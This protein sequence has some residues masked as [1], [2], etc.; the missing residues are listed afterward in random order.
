[1]LRESNHL[2]RRAFVKLAGITAA[3]SSLPAIAG[4]G[5][6]PANVVSL[7]DGKTLDGWIQ[8]ENNATSLTPAQIT[9]TAAFI[10]KIAKSTDALSSFLHTQLDDSIKTI[11]PTFS[12]ANTDAKAVLSAL[13]KNLNSVIAGP[14][15]YDAT[16]F[17]GIALRAETQTL[18]QH[19]P[20]G[21]QLAHLNKL[22][23]E[24]AFPAELAKT[25]ASGWIVKD[26]AMAS[27]GS[28]RGV[29]YTAKDYRRYRL[30]FTMRHLSGN[31]DHPAC[32]LIFCTGPQG[33]EKPID[34]LAGIQFE[35][36][37]GER[38][39]YR[40]GKNN[41]GGAEFTLVNKTQFNPQEWSRV[42]LLVDAENGT[43]RMAVAQ[44][45]GSK[46]VEVLDFKDPTAG[47]V[48]PIAWQMH[49]VGLFD[50]FKDITI[51]VNPKT[52]E[53]ITI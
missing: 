34:A 17:S 19:N 49:N 39:D 15:L 16:R 46:A 43:A 6:S 45:V 31:P 51:E 42:E 3:L 32:V 28:G 40:P 35:V 12:P 24:D 13:I 10:V 38:W 44:P 14:S 36:P 48:G 23:I 27:T 20:Q 1:M 53:L 4:V 30:L 52:S 22:L 33:D 29:I 5:G 37:N 18:L 7:F 21:Q 47:K 9:D 11:L 26:G 2:D 8:I 41:N 25:D 50:E